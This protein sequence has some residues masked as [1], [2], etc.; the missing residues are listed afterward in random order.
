MVAI[1]KKH[2]SLALI[3][4][5]YEFLEELIKN[6]LLNDEGEEKKEIDTDANVEVFVSPTPKEEQDKLD[7]QTEGINYIYHFL[8]DQ[9]IYQEYFGTY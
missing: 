9:G 1:K 4:E 5:N 2:H 8:W 6:F 3:G 7:G